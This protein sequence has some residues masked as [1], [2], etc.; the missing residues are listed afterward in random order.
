MHYTLNT[1]V[2]EGLWS[3]L[4]D[5]EDLLCGLC[6]CGRQGERPQIE[7]KKN[8][9]EC[10][11]PETVT[12]VNDE[13]INKAPSLCCQTSV[14]FLSGPATQSKYV[15]LHVCSSSSKHLG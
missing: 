7:K 2:H 14:W 8:I 3:R 12:N 6:G 15:C 9:T 13:L 4:K 1:A 11:D 5:D 10:K